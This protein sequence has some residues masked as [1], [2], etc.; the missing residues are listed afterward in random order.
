ML[1]RSI[2]LKGSELPNACAENV[3]SVGFRKQA[4]NPP[5]RIIA[6]QHLAPDEPI[7]TARLALSVHLQLFIPECDKVTVPT[8][9]VCPTLSS[10][11]VKRPYDVVSVVP[12]LGAI[13]RPGGQ[14][15]RHFSDVPV[16]KHVWSVDRCLNLY[17]SSTEDVPKPVPKFHL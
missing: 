2:G 10:D 4:F 13:L 15:N 11:V 7:G 16:P 5:C 14:F 17:F 9:K 3:H 12:G 6:L 8:P 1:R